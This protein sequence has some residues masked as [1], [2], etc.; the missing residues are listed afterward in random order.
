MT[1][2]QP[3]TITAIVGSSASG[4]NSSAT[5]TGGVH[6]DERPEERDRHEEPGDDRRERDERQ[7]DDD[8][9]D[10]RDHEVG[11]AHDRLAAQEPAERAR[12]RRLE[13]ARLVGVGRR[14]EPEEEGQDLVAVDDHVD[15]QEEHDQHRPDDAQARDRDLLERRDQDRGDVVEVVEDR[16]RLGQQVDLAEPDGV[17][18]VLPRLRRSPAGPRW[19]CGIEATN[20]A[21]EVASAPATTRRITTRIAT[22]PV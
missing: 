14:H 11:R 22:T 12:D 7:A 20:S 3:T 16:L 19:I 1:T 2:N 4:L 15:R 21:I 10:E 8:A 6:D 5:M 13:Q 17:Q 9:G 18:P